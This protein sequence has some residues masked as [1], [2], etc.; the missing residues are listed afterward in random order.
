MSYATVVHNFPELKILFY[1]PGS[2]KTINAI[3]NEYDVV[4][5]IP[6]YLND[7]LS[8]K[9]EFCFNSYS[10]SEM[11]RENLESYFT[12]LSKT[13]KY[14]ISENKHLD[15]ENQCFKPLLDYVPTYFKQISTYANHNCPDGCHDIIRFENTQ[16]S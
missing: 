5:I 13:T 16:M 3:I 6:D 7:F 15:T 9:I 14:L 8:C 2:G 11:T 4:M 1:C 12:F 10:F